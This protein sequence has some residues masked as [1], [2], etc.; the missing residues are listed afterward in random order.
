MFLSMYSVSHI[1]SWIGTVLRLQWRRDFGKVTTWT[2]KREWDTLKGHIRWKLTEPNIFN[3]WIS[4]YLRV[5]F[6]P[7]VPGSKS[8]QEG[9]L[10]IIT[11]ETP[12]FI[13]EKNIGFDGTIPKRVGSILVTH[14]SYPP[15]QDT[16][17]VNVL[18]LL[19]R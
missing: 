17:R 5:L 13:R 7:G 10:S 18:F 6:L 12:V 15:F 19:L 11:L 2:Y 4:E 14:K 16:K 8:W 3:D 1:W 9:G